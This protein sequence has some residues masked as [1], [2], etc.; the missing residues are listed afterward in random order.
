MFKRKG[1]V[2]TEISKP[3][4]K[5]NAF[6]APVLETKPIQESGSPQFDTTAPLVL[7]VPPGEPIRMEVSVSGDMPLRY[8]WEQWD[9]IKGISLPIEGCTEPSLTIALDPDDAMLAFQCRVSN[10]TAPDGVVSR[11]FFAKRVTNSQKSQNSFGEK[12]DPKL[13]NSGRV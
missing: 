2:P 5:S 11:T 6:G 10:P 7:R 12:F 8:Q 1:F 13:F 4:Q 3:T 9:D